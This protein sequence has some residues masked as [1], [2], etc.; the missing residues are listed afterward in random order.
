VTWSL[1]ANITISL[2]LKTTRKKVSSATLY[3]NN[4]SSVSEP[5]HFVAAPYPE[6]KNHVAPAPFPRR[7]L[8]IMQNK[9]KN[10]AVWIASRLGSGSS[11]ENDAAPCG[12]GS[13][14]LDKSKVMIVSNHYYSVN[15]RLYFLY[16]IYVCDVMFIHGKFCPLLFHSNNFSCLLMLVITYVLGLIMPIEVKSRSFCGYTALRGLLKYRA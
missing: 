14:T 2:S 13:K 5:D 15:N 3:V 6:K 16:K 12:S 9:I 8:Y 7:I 1:I 4:E 11:K 10:F